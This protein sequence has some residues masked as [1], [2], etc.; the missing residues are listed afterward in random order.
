[1]RQVLFFLCLGACAAALT[2]CGLPAAGESSKGDNAPPSVKSTQSSTPADSSTPFQTADVTIYIGMD[3]EFS[4]YPV[5]YA[6][7]QTETGQVPAAEVL[8]AM[9]ELTGWNLDLSDEVFTG[10]GGITVTFAATCT[11]LTGDPKQE[12]Q[13]EAVQQDQMVLDSVKRTLQCWAVDPELGDPDSVDVWFCGPDGGDLVLAGSGVTI[14][15]TEPYGEFPRN[16]R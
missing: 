3:G 15:S 11:L 1:M 14:S 5:D 6:G 13:T 9:A 4:E 8:S 16:D 12:T 10:R 7:E 2:A